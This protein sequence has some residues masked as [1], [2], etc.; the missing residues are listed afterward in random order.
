[1]IL[2]LL[3]VITQCRTIYQKRT[4]TYE[5]AHESAQKVKV[6]YLDNR[7]EFYNKIIAEND[8]I[9]GIRKKRGEVYRL[10]LPKNDIKE[11]HLP[12][13]TANQIRAAL[14]MIG[15]LIVPIFIVFITLYNFRILN[16]FPELV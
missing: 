3:S 4:S 5:E 16:S 7:K 15:I 14:I 8:E 10:I 2:L 9:I 6:I 12:N 11:I 1:M 13:K